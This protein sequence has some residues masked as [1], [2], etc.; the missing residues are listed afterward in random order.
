MPSST[1][2]CAVF[3]LDNAYNV[4]LHYP[5][6]MWGCSSAGRAQGW[7]SWGQGF[8]PPQ[9][10]QNKCRADRKVGPFVLVRGGANEGVW[11]RGLPMPWE[12]SREGEPSCEA[13]RV[14]YPPQ[15]HQ[16]IKGLVISDQPFFI[17]LC[18][19]CT[20]RK[21]EDLIHNV[22]GLRQVGRCKVGI[23]HGHF[24]ALVT[25]Q[26]R[27]RSDVDAT[28]HHSQACEC[29]PKIVKMEVPYPG[30][31]HSGIEAVLNV[32][33]RLQRPGS[34]KQYGT[35]TLSIFPSFSISTNRR[36]NLLDISRN[37]RL[38]RYLSPRFVLRF[39]Q[40]N[41]TV[42]QVY[43]LIPFEVQDFIAPHAR[44]Q[45]LSLSASSAHN[46]HLP[47]LRLL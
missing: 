1:G 17:W 40:D 12:S 41:E 23:L 39:V 2:I 27:Q 5:P 42:L 26:L 10:H 43:V 7:Q 4:M 34:W 35:I 11:G 32:R 28:R 36:G 38:I 46:R 31:F 6:Q 25:K 45:S 8:D 29:V 19:F 33:I 44:V 16:I 18:Q 3:F 15:L 22:C 14:R 20:S 13:K 9:L 24:K 37:V 30:F 47:G 21:A